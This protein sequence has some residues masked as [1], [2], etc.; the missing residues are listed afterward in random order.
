MVAMAGERVDLIVPTLNRR[1]D[2][3]VVPT[4]MGVLSEVLWAT[5]SKSICSKI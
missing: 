2:L 4:A 5:H 3:A 1:R